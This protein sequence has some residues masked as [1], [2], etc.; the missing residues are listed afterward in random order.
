MIGE[1]HGLTPLLLVVCRK[2]SRRSSNRPYKCACA[3]LSSQVGDLRHL[4]QTTACG[5]SGSGLS[6]SEQS[7]PGNRSRY[8]G[9][10][11]EV[12]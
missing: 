7:F 11:S 6:T 12:G 1:F 3:E 4:G 2:N 9:G 10:Q 8:K 5:P